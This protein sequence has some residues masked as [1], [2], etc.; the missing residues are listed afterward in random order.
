MNLQGKGLE[1]L[2]DPDIAAVLAEDPS[3]LVTTRFRYYV[4]GATTIPGVTTFLAME[5]VLKDRKVKELYRLRE[6]R[7]P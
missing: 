5:A 2:G 4:D 7:I 1:I 3:V 6:E